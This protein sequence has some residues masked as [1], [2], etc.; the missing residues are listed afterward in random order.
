MPTE[1]GTPRSETKATI[2]PKSKAIATAVALREFSGVGGAG[3]DDQFGFNDD[4]FWVGSVEIEFNAL[5]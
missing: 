1:D 4:G 2:E 3:A 5:Q